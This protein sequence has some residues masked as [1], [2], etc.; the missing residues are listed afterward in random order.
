MCAL[1]GRS[2]NEDAPVPYADPAP[3]ADPVAEIEWLP[4][5]PLEELTTGGHAVPVTSGMLLEEPAAN[6]EELR[7][8]DE[9]LRTFDEELRTFDE[10]LRAYD[11]EL[12]AYDEELRAL[13][14]LRAF[15]ELPLPQV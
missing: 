3:Y 1:Y 8:F 10:E 13:E 11:E 15:D 14:E 12:R 6:E 9:E 5:G 7:T 4:H 2:D